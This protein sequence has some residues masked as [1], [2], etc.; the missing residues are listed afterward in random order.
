MTRRLL[1]L[2]I[3]AM[4]VSAC[5]REAGPQP[6][7]WPGAVPDESIL[8][9]DDR[10]FGVQPQAVVNGEATF[11]VR[12]W[13]AD[14]AEVVATLGALLEID[15]DTWPLLSV[16]APE[17]EPAAST[18]VCE[19]ALVFESGG[20]AIGLVELTLS[21]ESTSSAWVWRI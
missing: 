17:C 14:S 18:D 21:Y 13:S 9:L 3:A 16:S 12:V 1:L 6:F 2:G 20:P 11:S 10:E 5:G 15:G 19:V 8:V 7:G 4:L